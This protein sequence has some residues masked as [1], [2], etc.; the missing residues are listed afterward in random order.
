MI[1]CT[2][3]CFEFLKGSTNCTATVSDKAFITRIE[4]LSN[5]FP[6]IFSIACKNDDGSIVAHFPVKLL[7]IRSP[8]SSYSK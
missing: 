8:R 2:E 3:N 1:K 7:T 5:K 6:Q 4:D